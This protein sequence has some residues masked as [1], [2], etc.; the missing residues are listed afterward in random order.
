MQ[1]NGKMSGEVVVAYF[2]VRFDK[3][4]GGT[5]ENHEHRYLPQL[6]FLFAPAFFISFCFFCNCRTSRST[7][8]IGRSLAENFT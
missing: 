3:S 2:M 1:D 8:A 6:M 7:L 4:C 5:D